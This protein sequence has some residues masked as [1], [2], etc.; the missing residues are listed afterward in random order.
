M[1]SVSQEVF[2][3]VALDYNAKS[4]NKEAVVDPAT[5]ALFAQLILDLVAKIRECRKSNA[6]VGQTIRNP[7]LFQKM[8][9]KRHLRDSMGTSDF[10]KHGDNMMASI[11]D[12]GKGLS[13]GE[14]DS[15]I[16]DSDMY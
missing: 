9:L 1:N 16:T 13:D 5:I 7:G 11:L 2:Q 6:E 8:S 15:L 12:T 10:R 3:K 4:G 14:I